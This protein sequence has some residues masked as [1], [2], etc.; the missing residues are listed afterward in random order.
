MKWKLKA[1]FN[2]AN[3]ISAT[4]KFTKNKFVT[5]LILLWTKIIFGIITP[6]KIDWSPNFKYYSPEL[7]GTEF[8]YKYAS[9][10]AN[11]FE[12]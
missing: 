4:D 9:D 2:I 10:P 5:V 8:D 6:R 7:L 1:Q 12:K 3:I 11:G